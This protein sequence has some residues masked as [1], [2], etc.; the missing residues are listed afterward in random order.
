MKSKRLFTVKNRYATHLDNTHFQ[1]CS[2]SVSRRREGDGRRAGGEH[3]GEE[4]ETRRGREL[5]R[6]VSAP[7]IQRPMHRTINVSQ[8]QTFIPNVP[9]TPCEIETKLLVSVKLWTRCEY[10]CFLSM[11][12]SSCGACSLLSEKL[13]FQLNLYM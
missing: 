13:M 4:T 3:P 5:S 8:H 1:E 6:A 7:C 10:Y 11:L 9:Q 12:M 2:V